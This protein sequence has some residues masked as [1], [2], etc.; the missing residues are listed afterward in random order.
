MHESVKFV[1]VQ[2]L[3]K[4][5]MFFVNYTKS[6]VRKYLCSKR[7]FFTVSLKKISKTV[8]KRWGG[9]GQ[10]LY[11]A[12]STLSCDSRNILYLIAFLITRPS[13]WLTIITLAKRLFSLE[14]I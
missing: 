6:L 7:F 11:Q 2:C 13:D 9:G 5:E 1:H 14:G 8:N 10:G 3:Y 12:I 4:R